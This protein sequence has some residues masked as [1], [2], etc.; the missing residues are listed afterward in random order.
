MYLDH[1]RAHR[2]SNTYFGRQLL[3][4]EPLKTRAVKLAKEVAA[5]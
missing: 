3:R 4:P 1:L 2:S 5:A